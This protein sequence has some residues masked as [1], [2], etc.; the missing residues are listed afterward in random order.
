MKTVVRYIHLSDEFKCC[1]HFIFGPCQHVAARI[2]GEHMRTAT[3]WI[4][5][6]SIEGMPIRT[7]ELKILFHGFPRNDLLGIIIPKGQ[8]ILAVS[9]FELNLFNSLEKFF[10]SFNYIHLILN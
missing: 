6:V 2:P 9:A 8:R 5:T 7:G 1:I 4:R 3:K 10:L